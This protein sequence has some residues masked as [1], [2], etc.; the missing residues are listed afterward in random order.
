MVQADKS[1]DLGKE[2]GEVFLKALGKAAGND[3]LLLFSGRIGLAGIDGFNDGANGFI[4][5][6]IN[7][8]AGVDDER[9]GQ[10]GI[11]H[12]GHSFR[13]KV[14]EHDLGVDEVLGTAK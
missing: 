7:K 13:L 1:V 11:G 2:A 12:E 4:L 14:S 9:V 5:G 6:D 10:F 3:D 8:G